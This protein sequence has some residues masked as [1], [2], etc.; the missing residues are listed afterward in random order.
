MLAHG[1][2]ERGWLGVSVN[3]TVKGGGLLIAGLDRN[4]P[5]ARAGIRPGDML[6]AVNGERID[7]ANGLIKAIAAVPPGSNVR[8]TLRRQG[9]DIDIPVTVGRRPVEQAG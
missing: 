9:R 5:A 1:Q 4:S 6:M 3:D 7:T 2:I 8:L